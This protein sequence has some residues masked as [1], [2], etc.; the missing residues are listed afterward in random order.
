MPGHPA[1]R[2]VSPL[3]YRITEIRSRRPVV[4]TW[5]VEFKLADG[6]VAMTRCYVEYAA[7]ER[8]IAAWLNQ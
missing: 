2:G 8:A 4:T 6:G 3:S 1:G 5:M 7:A